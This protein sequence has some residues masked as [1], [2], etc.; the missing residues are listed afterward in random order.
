MPRINGGSKVY[1]VQNQ[2]K[3][4]AGGNLIPKFDLEPARVYG[5]LVFVL[6]PAADHGQP[7]KVIDELHIRLREM[8]KNDYLLLLGNPCLIGWCVAVASHYT[9]GL[10]K[11]L[12]WESRT[13][14]Y[15]AVSCDLKV[16]S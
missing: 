6:S 7:N 5:P 2:Y 8:T 16:S 12:Q 1:V 3:S 15:L 11:L 4:T 10:L 14:S 13:K 9:G